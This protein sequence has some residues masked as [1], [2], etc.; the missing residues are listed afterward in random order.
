MESLINSE[1]NRA[2]E[3]F[4]TAKKTKDPSKKKEL[5]NS[6]CDILKALIDNYPS[7][8]LNQKLKSHMAI[9]KEELE[10]IQ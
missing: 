7:S 3:I 2:A 4:L 10:S 5:L 1:R 6:S 8:P 9:V